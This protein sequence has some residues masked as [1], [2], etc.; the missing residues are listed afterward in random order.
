MHVG[1]EIMDPE[2]TQ[3]RDNRPSMDISTPKKVSWTESSH[4]WGSRKDITSALVVNNYQEY[5]CT[6]RYFEKDQWNF[7]HLWKCPYM[8]SINKGD[9]ITKKIDII[10]WNGRYPEAEEIISYRPYKFKE[11][12]VQV[13]PLMSDTGNLHKVQ[14]W[15]QKPN[16][17]QKKAHIARNSEREVI[18]ATKSNQIGEMSNYFT[19]VLIDGGGTYTNLGKEFVILNEDYGIVGERNYYVPKGIGVTI[20]KVSED[21]MVIMLKVHHAFTDRNRKS[22][23]SANHIRSAYHKV[24]DAPKE[25]GGWQYIEID[26]VDANF[27]KVPLKYKN[28]LIWVELRKPTY[29]EMQYMVP[30]DFTPEKREWTLLGEPMGI[31]KEGDE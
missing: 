6:L 31:K 25:F 23:L 19:D 7:S 26:E 10:N 27:P 22:I 5:E 21:N 1:T 3:I 4:E 14:Y 11:E 12:W 24:F 17:N 15:E 2:G 29:S 13:S 20:A 9:F 28:G 30:Y 8:I 16:F 18:K